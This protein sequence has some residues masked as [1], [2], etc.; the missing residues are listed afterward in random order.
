[1]AGIFI[2]RAAGRGRRL[3][4]SFTVEATFIL[5]VVLMTMAFVIK[6][7]YVSHDQIT[8]IMILE[9]TVEKMRCAWEK[10]EISGLA[11]DGELLGNPRLWL[12]AY[13]IQLDEEGKKAKGRAS[14]GEW[15]GEIEM[16]KFQPGQFLRRY[17]ALKAIGEWA[18][19]DGS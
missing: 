19:N 16:A 4:A 11:R 2:G 6:S 12:G 3:H 10:E 8:G 7:A 9:E 5:S 15:S 18:G 17:Q 13:Q 1:M 14:A